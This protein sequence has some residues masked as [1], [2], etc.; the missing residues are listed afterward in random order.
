MEEE[1]N[2]LTAISDE[3][4]E[5]KETQSNIEKSLKNTLRISEEMLATETADGQNYVAV[6]ETR[7]LDIHRKLDRLTVL[8]TQTRE[9]AFA[10]GIASVALGV[11][12]VFGIGYIII[13]LIHA[14]L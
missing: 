2:I 3:I 8:Q 12:S 4:K 13:K 14:G 7:I 5:I 10:L 11:V 9:H 1:S 6:T